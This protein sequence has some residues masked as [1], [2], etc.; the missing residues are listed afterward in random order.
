MAILDPIKLVI[1]NYPEGQ[2]E[3][4][5]APNNLENEAL[6]SES[7]RSAVNFIYRK[8]RFYG[9]TSKE[10]FPPVPWK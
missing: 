4:L 8:G 5:D 3:E 2:I 7:F 6:G 1:D 10:V 9:R